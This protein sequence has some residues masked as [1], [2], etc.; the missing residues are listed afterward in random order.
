MCTRTIIFNV[1]SSIISK[2]GRRKRWEY[3]IIECWNLANISREQEKMENTGCQV[4]CCA[5]MILTIKG[6]IRLMLAVV[7]VVMVMV[8][9]MMMRR[10]IFNV[11]HIK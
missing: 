6:M 4:I 7:V 11:S 3:N 5:P 8:V 2:V 1:S 9:M 10:S